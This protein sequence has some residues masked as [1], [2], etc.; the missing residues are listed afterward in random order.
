MEINTIGRRLAAIMMV[1]VVGYSK[2][3]RD[4]EEGTIARVRLLQ[5]EL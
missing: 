5:K 1:D 2:L 3:V 4:D